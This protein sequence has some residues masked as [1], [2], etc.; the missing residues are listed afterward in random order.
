M[1]ALSIVVPV[2]KVEAYI[3]KCV[4]SILDNRRFDSDCELIVVDD[5]SPDGSM[6]I[7]ERLC[8]GRSNV[9]LVRQDNQGLGMARNAGQVRA[10]GDY[11]WFVDSD[12][13]LPPGAVERV[14]QQV[15]QA[16][17][18]VVNIDYVMSDGRRT[19]V[20]NHAVP[21]QVYA[22]LAY[23]A[24]SIVQNPVQYYVFKLGFYRQRQLQFAKGLYHEDALFTPVALSQAESVVR[25][26]ADCYVYNLREGSIMS[27]ANPARHARDMLDVAR[28]LDAFRR[29]HATDGRAARIVSGYTARAIGGVYYYWRLLDPAQRRQLLRSP[30][31][32]PLLSPIALARAWKYLLSLV[33]MRYLPWLP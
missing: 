16:R 3:E 30:D 29:R 21:G 13:W 15:S 9:T 4:R 31:V 33:H 8:S 23:L 25:L 26:G 12:D 20:P 24:L 19:T 17:P 27:A 5:G 22:G 1:Y 6:A 7:V 2:F 11:L 28:Q 32:G 10:R 14:L 18:D